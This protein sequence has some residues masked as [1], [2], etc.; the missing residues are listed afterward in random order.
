MGLFFVH[1]FEFFV[2]FILIYSSHICENFENQHV[3]QTVIKD[4]IIQLGDIN[5]KVLIISF[6]CM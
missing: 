6:Q 2:Q 5:H 1:S 3:K 4:I